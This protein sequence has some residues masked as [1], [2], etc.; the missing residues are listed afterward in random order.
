MWLTSAM[1]GLFVD[2]S[3]TTSKSNAAKSSI[4]NA[5]SGTSMVKPGRCDTPYLGD[6]KVTLSTKTGF[7][8]CFSVIQLDGV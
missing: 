6:G 8:F 7:S 2:L 1:M 5:N 4:S 3:V